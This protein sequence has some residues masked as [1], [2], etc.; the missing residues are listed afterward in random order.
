MDIGN[1]TILNGPILSCLLFLLQLVTISAQSK[2]TT[3]TLCV[4]SI[5]LYLL[6]TMGKLLHCTQFSARLFDD[7]SMSIWKKVKKSLCQ[8]MRLTIHQYFWTSEEEKVHYIII[9]K[10]W[11]SHGSQLWNSCRLKYKWKNNKLLIKV[12]KQKI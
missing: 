10:G 12:K 3:D 4:C 1:F 6:N 9:V 7:T 2:Y 11:V 8:C 5:Y